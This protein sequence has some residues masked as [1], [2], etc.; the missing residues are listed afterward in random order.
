MKEK[1][2]KIS[3]DS[4]RSFLNK[5]KWRKADNNLLEERIKKNYYEANKNIMLGK[6]QDS[7]N[8]LFK[9]V[10]LESIK[11]LDEIEKKAFKVVEVKKE[12]TRFDFYNF[13]AMKHRTISLENENKRMIF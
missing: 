5:V 13:D 2:T 9:A 7:F 10:H 12:K 3:W 11:N 6:K 8:A 4:F 1:E